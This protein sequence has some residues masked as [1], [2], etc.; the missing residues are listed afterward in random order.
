M[1]IG[2]QTQSLLRRQSEDEALDHI[3]GDHY[4]ID[5]IDLPPHGAR[6]IENQNGIFGRG[7]ARGQ[8]SEGQSRGKSGTGY[9]ESGRVHCC[10]SRFLLRFMASEMYKHSGE[11]PTLLRED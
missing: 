2:D 9:C 5:P 10:T 7:R 3:L 11:A 4:F 1:A 6:G 8:D